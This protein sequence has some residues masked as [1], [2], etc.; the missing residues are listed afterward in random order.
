MQ[1]AVNRPLHSAGGRLIQ[2]LRSG[3]SA[4]R[5]GCCCMAAGPPL[6]LLPGAGSSVS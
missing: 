3:T 2:Q 6:L 5:R 1:P 4:T